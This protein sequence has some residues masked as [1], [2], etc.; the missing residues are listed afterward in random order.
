VYKLES[1]ANNSYSG[2]RNNRCCNIFLGPCKKKFKNQKYYKKIIAVKR[3][4]Q[5]AIKIIKNWLKRF[6][7]TKIKI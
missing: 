3:G 6:K 5:N 4:C 2:Q 7:N 1:S